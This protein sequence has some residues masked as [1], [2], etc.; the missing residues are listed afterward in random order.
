MIKLETAELKT[1]LARVKPF[2]SS[3]NEAYACVR[4]NIGAG[5]CVLETANPFG[6]A[7]SR[8]DA[9]GNLEAT[10]DATKFS[11][12]LNRISGDVLSMKMDGGNLLIT[13]GKTRLSLPVFQI[14]IPVEPPPANG[15][16]DCTVNRE[17][18]LDRSA[19]CSWLNTPSETR[20]VQ[21][22]RAVTEAGA[23]FVVAST[24]HAY[25]CTSLEYQGADLDAILPHDSVSALNS[26]LKNCD[27]DSVTFVGFDS[28]CAALAGNFSCNIRA[29]H[30]AK[31]RNPSS[32]I[33][34][35]DTADEWQ[36]EQQ[37]V[38]GILGTI[39]IFLTECATGLWLIP[40]ADGLNISFTGESDGTLAQDQAVQGRCADFAAGV[41]TG[42]QAYMSHKFLAPMVK[43]ATEKDFVILSGPGRLGVSSEHYFAA[44]STMAEPIK[45]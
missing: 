41:C 9:S 3:K 30:G 38:N 20:I 5:S 13:S 14:R 10:V 43:N 17:E 8:F 42:N 24:N 35:M 37:D 33:P 1:H 39:G 45:K 16:L 44:A 32:I 25:A 12:A 40:Q 7:R 11:Q 27:S 28:Y 23:L 6:D 22:V 29:T 19:R 4:I 21:A 18:W 31:P 34:L 15:A 26:A 2:S 36:V